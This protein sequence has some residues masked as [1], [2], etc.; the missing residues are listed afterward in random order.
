MNKLTSVKSFCLG[1]QLQHSRHI[2]NCA[3]YTT[4]AALLCQC[5]IVKKGCKLAFAQYTHRYYLAPPL[6]LSKSKL[7]PN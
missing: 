7:R 3:D 2:D 1:V 6:N 5:A 4:T